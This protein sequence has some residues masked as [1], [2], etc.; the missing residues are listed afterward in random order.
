MTIG[1]KHYH[2]IGIGGTAMASLAGLL[3]AAGHAVTGSDEGVYPPMSNLLHDLGIPY[4][5]GYAPQNLE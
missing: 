2:L 3:K 1:S 5:E 4:R